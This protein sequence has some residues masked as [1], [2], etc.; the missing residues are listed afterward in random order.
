MTPRTN[1]RFAVFSISMAVGALNFPVS[2][3]EVQAGDGMGEI[4]LIPTGMAGDTLIVQAA[5]LLSGGMAGAAIQLIVKSIERPAG[6]GVSE[7]GFLFAIMALCTLVGFVAVTA[8]RVDLGL[9]PLAYF[10]RLQVVTIRA[11]FLLV[12][13][14]TLQAKQLHMFF[15]EKSDHRSRL[16]GRSVHFGNRSRDHRMGGTHDIG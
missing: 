8:Y 10:G 7:S 16:I 1:R 9:R 6:F 14:D 3:I 13:A 12:T 15:V 2:F 5:D 4:P 11:V